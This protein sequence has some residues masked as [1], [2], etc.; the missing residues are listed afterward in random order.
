[1]GCR[2]AME[3]C[4]EDEINFYNSL[5]AY[6]DL[7]R[8]PNANDSDAEWDD[9]EDMFTP[10]GETEM[11]D[12]NDVN[13]PPSLRNKHRSASSG[14]H[15]RCEL[16]LS[17]QQI[18]QLEQTLDDDQVDPA[19]LSPLFEETKTLILPELFKPMAPYKNQNL[20]TINLD[21]SKD[22]NKDVPQA[23]NNSPVRRRG[24][25]PTPPR[26]RKRIV[27]QQIS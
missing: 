14:Y 7:L 18:P 5:S 4:T 17:E 6:F 10:Y 12:K 25:S 20:I 15:I 8:R 23:S 26:R 11:M 21:D 19:T 27:Q 13:D 22:D 1:M 9:T 2:D 3:L 16:C 24:R